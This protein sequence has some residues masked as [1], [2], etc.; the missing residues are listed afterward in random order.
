MKKI[1][2]IIGVLSILATSANASSYWTSL[3]FLV[4][5]IYVTQEVECLVILNLIY[6]VEQV[7]IQLNGKLNLK[8]P[9]LLG[10]F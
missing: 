8:H 10:C 6:L 1:A 4:V 9:N 7:S 2:M 5:I 3:T